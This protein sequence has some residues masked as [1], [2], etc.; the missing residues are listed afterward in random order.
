MTRTTCPVANCHVHVLATCFVPHFKCRLAVWSTI[1]LPFACAPVVD[2]FSPVCWPPMLC[3]H[4]YWCKCINLPVVWL[5]VLC[6][7]TCVGRS[8]VI[9]PHTA[10]VLGGCVASIATSGDI[11]YTDYTWL[12][13]LKLVTL[14][15]GLHITINSLDCFC[16]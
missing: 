13:G 14:T 11:G 6:G 9:D 10:A 7:P 8:S 1:C 3:R 16:K 4:Y 2:E 5:G 15:Y 12:H